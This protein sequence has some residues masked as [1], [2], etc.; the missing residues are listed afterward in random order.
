M[1]F[2]LWFLAI[3][4]GLFV[5]L[6]IAL[7]GFGVF[8]A[9]KGYDLAKGAS[10][11]ANETIAA[12]GAMWDPAALTDRAAPELLAEVA[13]N[14]DALAQLSLMLTTQAGALLSATPA[15]CSNFNYA[16]TTAGGDVFTAQCAAEG[17]VE[18]GAAQFS[19]NVINRN[20]EWRLLG[21]FVFVTPNQ[22]VERDGSKL[23]NFVNEDAASPSLIEASVGNRT[24][25]LSIATRSMSLATGRGPAIHAGAGAEIIEAP[26]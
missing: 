17:V 10:A 26:R 23:V 3:L 8:G 14:P 9:K 18:K 20:R 5:L 12:Y 19:V 24:L 1:R 16:A 15:T 25:A 13:R 21:F 6:L 2:F 4:G 7:F 22:P 11:Y